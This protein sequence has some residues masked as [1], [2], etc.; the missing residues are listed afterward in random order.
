MLSLGLAKGKCQIYKGK[1]FP[2]RNNEAELHEILNSDKS[3]LLYPSPN[4]IPIESLEKENGPY[5][6][7]LLDG[8]WPQSKAIYCSSPLLHKMKQVKLISSGTS[9][10]VFFFLISKKNPLNYLCV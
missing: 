4:S 8:T 5:N 7:I 6:I 2:N 9:W 10:Y 1:R 3:I